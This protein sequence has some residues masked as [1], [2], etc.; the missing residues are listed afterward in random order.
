MVVLE[1]CL[2]ITC[3]KSSSYYPGGKYY[4]T[5]ENKEPVVNKTHHNTTL[6]KSKPNSFEASPFSP[7]PIDKI[8]PEPIVS[9]LPT[10]LPTS[11]PTPE[12]TPTPTP[13]PTKHEQVKQPSDVK[14]I[15]ITYPANWGNKEK[16]EACLTFDDGYD[17]NSLSTALK[18]LKKTGVRCTFFITGEA[19]RTHP[20]LY[21]EAVK[22]GHQ[23]CNHTTSHKYLNTLSNDG[24]KN[25]L[26]GWANAVCDVLGEQYLENMKKEYPYMRLPGGY[27]TSDERVLKIV[28][29]EGYIPVGWSDETVYSILRHYNLKNE[30]VDPIAERIVQHIRE[31][32]QNGSIILLHF[33]SFD[34]G[35]LEEIIN[36]IKEKGLALKL[37]SEVLN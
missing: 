25:E 22:D 34:I 37:V 5:R 33:N 21:K 9:T 3:S 26:R 17:G 31:N 1:L 11:S 32:A 23:I 15:Q 6:Y 29:E 30:P 14:N 19:L 18:V 7:A 12:P 13:V 27:G 10:P 28:A 35:R 24:I 8:T 20:D 2:L 36:S 16:A 4:F